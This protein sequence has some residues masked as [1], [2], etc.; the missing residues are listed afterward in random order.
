MSRKSSDE[1]DL[2]YHRVKVELE[3][4]IGKPIIYE[5]DS[6]RLPSQYD[7]V[8]DLHIST[9]KPPFWNFYRTKLQRVESRAKKW[10]ILLIAGRILKTY[11]DESGDGKKPF[12]RRIYNIPSRDYYERSQNG[13]WTEGRSGGFKIHGVDLEGIPSFANFSDLI[14]SITK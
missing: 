6:L 11:D 13:S 1:S 3:K 4:I 14:S 5:N 12:I 8:F 10:S 2:I 9:N 7:H